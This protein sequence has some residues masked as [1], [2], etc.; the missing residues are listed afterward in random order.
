MTTTH[1]SILILSGLLTACAGG[2]VGEEGQVGLGLC[3]VLSSQ[4]LALDEI[5][6]IDDVTPNQIIADLLGENTGPMNWED[7]Q[8]TTGAFNTSLRQGDV[9]Y[10]EMVLSKT[11]VEGE[12]IPDHAVE[13][14]DCVSHV[15]IPI[16]Q[17]LETTNGRLNESYEGTLKVE[18]KSF[19]KAEF[20]P[21]GYAG[22]LQSA[23]FAPEGVSTFRDKVIV[24]RNSGSDGAS[25]AVQGI[26]KR[27]GNPNVSF[28]IGN[29]VS[30]N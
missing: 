13:I 21:T 30:D 9:E 1:F 17:T 11:F 18:S 3:D 7:G 8:V 16:T 14:G 22:T 10:R 20:F 19:G 4:V 15:A 26:Y 27:N 24:F 28:P 29:L 6:P 25:V 5:S 23:D 12:T 2:Q